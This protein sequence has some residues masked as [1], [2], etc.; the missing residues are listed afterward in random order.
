M[1]IKHIQRPDKPKH[2]DEDEI[3]QALTLM[4]S[5][6]TLKTNPSYIKDTQDSINLLPFQEKHMTYLKGHPKVN[7]QHYLSNLRTMIKKRI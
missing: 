4:E 2:M 3:R 6:S 1:N 7:P 5:D